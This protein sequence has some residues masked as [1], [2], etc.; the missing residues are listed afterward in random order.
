MGD[1]RKNILQT[2][3][4]GKKLLQG[5]T[6]GKISYT[7]KKKKKSYTFACQRKIYHQRF[8]KIIFTQAKSPIPPSQVEG[9]ERG[10]T[11]VLAG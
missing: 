2:D 9:E 1:F 3:F 8:G 6:W 5:N 4:E 10:E 7:E 11:D